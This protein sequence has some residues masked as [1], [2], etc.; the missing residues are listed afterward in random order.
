MRHPAFLSGSFDTNFIETHFT[1]EQLHQ[2]SA[3]EALIAALLASHL[4]DQG[5]TKASVKAPAY[6]EKSKWKTNRLNN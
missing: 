4:H 1:P 5:N 3:D 6:H 2:T